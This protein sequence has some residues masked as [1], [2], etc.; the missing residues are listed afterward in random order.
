MERISSMTSDVNLQSLNT[1]GL[2]RLI[3]GVY[4]HPSASNRLRVLVARLFDGRKFEPPVDLV[5][6]EFVD[7]IAA[8]EG[9]AVIWA[10]DKF[11][12]V[13][14]YWVRG[15]VFA[16]LMALIDDLRAAQNEADLDSFSYL[17]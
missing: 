4:V 17:D 3:D 7:V 5:G 10:T 11:Q 12:L 9:G 14:P 1:L 13:Q 6:W 15:S 8:R 16:E 2:G